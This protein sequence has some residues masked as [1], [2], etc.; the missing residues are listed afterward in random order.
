[1]KVK[2]NSFKCSVIYSSILLQLTFPFILPGNALAQ[3]PVYEEMAV[4]SVKLQS[5]Q[6]V[7]DI[8]KKNHLSVDHLWEVNSFA[9]SNKD[10]FMA[11]HEG[12]K[13]WV[14]ANK[15]GREE[16]EMAPTL[17]TA[18]LH[19]ANKGIERSTDALQLGRSQLSSMAGKQ[20]ES[21]LSKFGGS[22]RVSLGGSK[23]FNQL[24]Y[25]A[26]VLVPVWDSRQ[27]FLLFSQLGGR[28]IDDRTTVNVGFGGRY[29]TQ[30]AVKPRPSGR[31]YKAR[32][33]T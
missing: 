6:T 9:F 31:G 29:F 17:P 27:D 23:D 5:G 7:S 28:R 16:H 26:D 21:L 11:A 30:C 8:A 19:S 4:Q 24:N 13:I 25:A 20:A 18:A 14:P 33:S 15:N 2:K 32:F 10:R 3:T 12:D 1:M 22:S